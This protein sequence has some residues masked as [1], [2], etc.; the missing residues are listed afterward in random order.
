MPSDVFYRV[1]Q[2]PEDRT[3]WDGAA[4][5]LHN[6]WSAVLAEM[7]PERTRGQPHR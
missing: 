1:K 2:S 5:C 6:L 7:S 4:V 3:Q